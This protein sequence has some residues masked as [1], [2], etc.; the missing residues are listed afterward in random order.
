VK[1]IEVDSHAKSISAIDSFL[2]VTRPHIL[3]AILLVKCAVTRGFIVQCQ[4]SK[5]RVPDHRDTSRTPVS[6]EQSLNGLIALR[7][8]PSVDHPPDLLVIK[9]RIQS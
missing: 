3:A 4:F 7:D 1:I 6:A 5:G 9:S 2:K 8:Y